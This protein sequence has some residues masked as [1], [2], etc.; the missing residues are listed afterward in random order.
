MWRGTWVS[1]APGSFLETDP[2]GS[3][4]RGARTPPTGRGA[5]RT[6]GVT[7]ILLF[8]SAW[9]CCLGWRRSWSTSAA[10][11]PRATC[12]RADGGSLRPLRT[13]RR[14]LIRERGHIRC[15]TRIVGR[16]V[17]GISPRRAAGRR[18]PPARDLHLHGRRPHG[19]RHD[20]LPARRGRHPAPQ[21]RLRASVFTPFPHSSP[22]SSETTSEL[23]AG[24]RLLATGTSSRGLVGSHRAEPH[25]M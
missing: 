10:R 13:C 7:L 20:A 23:F 15:C 4:G 14:V 21:P 2:S 5:P 18:A 3:N 25:R 24:R 16:Y 12:R 11:Q 1:C 17:T 9:C 8:R 6:A 22:A 19:D